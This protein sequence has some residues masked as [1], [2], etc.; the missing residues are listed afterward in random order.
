M[1]S[2]ILLLA[3]SSTRLESGVKKQFIKFHNKELFIFPLETFYKID[4]I[5]N[6]FLVCQKGDFDH[7]NDVL[8]EYNFENKEIY[9]VEGGLTRQKSVFNAL[10]FIYKNNIDTDN[11]IIHDV[12]RFL[13]DEEII[14]ENLKA[15][16][17]YPGT[18]TYLD[19]SDSIL[20]INTNYDIENYLNRDKIKKVQTPQAFKFDIIIEAHEKYEDVSVNDDAS[21][22]LMEHQNIKLVRGSPLNFK[23]TTNEDLKLLELI[24]KGKYEL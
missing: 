3:G 12:A 16:E 13:V 18:T 4:E 24:L 19:E 17:N 2:A 21:L 9:L 10:K 15:L 22:L 8:S 20:T 1:T 11:V 5:N 7:I 14:L 23:V 6:I